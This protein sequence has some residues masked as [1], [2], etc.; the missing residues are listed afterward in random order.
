MCIKTNQ[1]SQ[2]KTR[3]FGRDRK[4]Y[5][6]YLLFFFRYFFINFI[7]PTLFTVFL[8]EMCN[9]GVANI[10]RSVL[11]P[12]LVVPFLDNAIEKWIRLNSGDNH[13]CF[14]LESAQTY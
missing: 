9:K 1:P 2:N 11:H 13:F 12:C 8:L 5:L 7:F 3:I 6:R 10:V 4:G 14:K